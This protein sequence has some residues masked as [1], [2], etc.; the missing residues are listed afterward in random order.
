LAAAAFGVVDTAAAEPVDVGDPEDAFELP[1]EAPE[2]DPAPEEAEVEGDE[3]PDADPDMSVIPGVPV[4]D[5]DSEETEPCDAG[6]DAEPVVELTTFV[7]DETAALV[8]DP[9]IVALD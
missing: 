1:D 5:G 2:E 7:G 8:I 6:L 4:D 3:D 9:V